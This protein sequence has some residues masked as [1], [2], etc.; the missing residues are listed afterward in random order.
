MGSMVGEQ[1]SES[2]CQMTRSPKPCPSCSVSA[3]SA[4]IDDC[5]LCG[6]PGIKPELDA[7]TRQWFEEYRDREMDQEA[8]GTPLPR[9]T[10][11]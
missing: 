4:E 11:Q 2:R 7:I 6:T 3:M 1:D 9:V 10:I 8:F 5:L